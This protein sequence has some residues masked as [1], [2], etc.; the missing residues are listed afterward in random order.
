MCGL[1][2]SVTTSEDN[3][4]SSTSD[5]NRTIKITPDK[6]DP[7]SRGSMCPKAPMLAELHSDPERLRYPVRRVANDWM[8]ISWDEAID[9]VCE[10]FQSIRAEYG[11]DAI[12]SYLGNPIVHNLGMLLY[13][14]QLTEAIGSRN[15]FSATSMDQLPHHFAAHHMF[16]HEF[17]IPVPDVDRTDFMIIMGANPIASNGSIMT[18]AG[19]RERLQRV[20]ERGGQLVVIDPRRT[21]TAELADQHLFI[22]PATDV[23]FL[24]AFMHVLFRDKLIRTARLQPYLDDDAL[25]ALQQLSSPYTPAVASAR[26]G[27][28]AE[29]ITSLVQ[30]YADQPCAVLYGRMGVSTQQHGGLCHWL[31]NSINIISGHFDT[32][33]GM[34]FPQPAIE[35]ARGRKQ[36][37]HQSRWFSRVRQLP[38][39]YG[40]LPVSTM[41]EEMLTPG[42][43]QIRGL[44]T[45]CGN[46]VLSTPN[47]KRLEKALPSLDFMVSID[48][49]INETTRHADV[50]IPTPCG[51]EIDHY[52]V[53]F[54]LISVSNNV[55]F[56]EA[57]FPIDDNRLYDWQILKRL[58][59]KLALKSGLL[60]RTLLQW[61]TPRR[62][63][64]WGLMLGAYGCLGHPRRW[65]SGLS[66]QRVI[67]S[68]HGIDL[69]PMQPRVPEGL[70]TDDRKIHLAPAIFTEAIAALTPQVTISNHSY[71]LRLIG[72]RHVSTNNSWMHQFRK[73]S[74][75]RQV[76]CTAMM[77][78]DDAS[79]RS[80]ENGATVRVLSATGSIELDAEVTD[81]MMPGAICIPHGFGH[82]GNGTRISNALRKPG[83]SVNDITDEQHIDQVT[84][85]A[86]FS[87]LPV[88]VEKI[89]DTPSVDQATENQSG[90]PLLI[91]YGSRTGNAEFLA[92]DSA[93]L[94]KQ[95]G[96]LPVVLPMNQANPDTLAE[97]PRLLI[98]CSTYGEGDMPDNA[99]SLWQRLQL[100]DAP[101]L[102]N[103]GFAVLALGDRS[104]D[105]FC[106]AGKDWDQQLAA[107]GATRL[108]GRVDCDVDYQ[109]T[110]DAWLENALPELANYGD[111][112]TV[113]ASPDIEPDSTNAISRR[114]PWQAELVDKQ[115]LSGEASVQ[116]V[117]HYALSVE[118]ADWNYQPG[119][120]VNLLVE[121]SDQQVNTLLQCFPMW[122]SAV[123]DAGSANIQ[124]SASTL[125][126]QLRTSFEWVK[127]SR[128]L[129]RA[130]ADTAGIT[131]LETLLAT[132]RQSDIDHWIDGRDVPDLLQAYSTLFDSPEALLPLLTPLQPRTYSIASSPLA[133]P[134]EIHITV[135]T[136]RRKRRNRDYPGLA[137]TYLADGLQ[138]GGHVHIYPA[139][140]SDFKLPT[141]L[142]TPI[143]MIGPGT[144]LAPFR[145]FLQH[146]SQRFNNAGKNPD[147]QSDQKQ[148]KTNAG[149]AWLFFGNPNRATDY[150]Y[151][152]ELESFLQEGTLTQIDLAFSR[153]QQDKIY[154]QHRLIESGEKVSY[155]L[156]QGATI[157]IC[158][159]AT[160]MAADVH[161]ALQKILQTHKQLSEAS[162][163]EQLQQLK[164]AG[165]YLLDV[166]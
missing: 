81:S 132:N 17:R 70:L 44:M 89:A 3:T 148:A 21:E 34:M 42:A 11:A 93:A 103:T 126:Q 134:D 32:P 37:K 83:V 118:G 152:Q 43:G 88:Q 76:R 166:Y 22:K 122:Q 31:I 117:Y 30:Q 127:P 129:L 78:P 62:I 5:H 51:L 115:L 139:P 160:H 77:H 36:P 41:A 110:A 112:T 94:A 157:Y 18:S 4:N 143:I 124:Q 98:I 114:N 40:E 65:F 7:F 137:S 53:I 57:L 100:A 146:R 82:H 71:P 158:G 28:S 74:A 163:R 66:L 73:L 63:I 120:S 164:D 108:T 97:S 29:S 149:K 136:V 111:Q 54:N 19:I 46:P 27:I 138:V 23:Y 14:K 105:T 165:R 58:I 61:S 10:Q 145:G 2:V 85:N 154:V 68:G 9:F 161:L 80:I 38:E 106:A 15:V 102:S 107:M 150:L 86:A 101:P 147:K 155:W 91:L 33:G 121:N 142:S 75:S 84:G 87:G 162:A 59:T 69:G 116:E 20:G 48:N 13:I 12:G 67:D 8:E 55:K 25:S 52:D 151:K 141:A 56:S 130:I 16:G 35:L 113:L 6:R 64:N 92:R 104:Y 45:V 156:D 99:E 47:G 125:R 49:Y 26:T 153:D 119:D 131:E 96:L 95:H 39:F 144:G 1:Q 60:K 50:I 72:R 140:A 133:H 128:K 109:D 135:S 24:L 90:L 79:I 159:D 123:D